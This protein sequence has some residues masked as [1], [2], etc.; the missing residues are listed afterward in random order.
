MKIDVLFENMQKSRNHF[1]VVLDEYGGTVGIITMNDLLEEIVGDLENEENAEVKEPDIKQI[2]E[3]EW[4]IQGCASLD[5]VERNLKIQLPID[6][7]ETFS[8][9]VF[10]IYCTIPEDNTSFSLE[11]DK[12][13]INVLNVVNHTVEKASVIVKL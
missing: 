9:Y 6:E 5:D 2:N 1:S 12:L 4:T 8:G 11:T 13:I 10:G 7:Y 3:N